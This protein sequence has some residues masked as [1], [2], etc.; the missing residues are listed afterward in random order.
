M[1][2]FQKVIGKGDAST[3]RF[4][5]GCLFLGDA[6]VN[7]QILLAR[8]A[9]SAMGGS[10]N[11]SGG[12]KENDPLSDS[13]FITTAFNKPRFYIFSHK[14]PIAGALAADEEHGDGE[15]VQQRQSFPEMY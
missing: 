10:V 3:L 11:G 15:E 13:L 6:K 1:N 5:G 8:A 12:G 14:D 9:D 2:K 4:L 7:K